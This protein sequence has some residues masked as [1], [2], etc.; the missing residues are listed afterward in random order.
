MAGAGIEVT[1]D[2]QFSKILTALE[3]ASMPDLEAVADFMGGELHD[4]SNTAFQKRADPVTGEGWADLKQP[5]KGDKK[6]TL[7]RGGILFASRNWITEGG[8]FICGSNMEYARIHQEGG[9]TKAYEIKARNGKALSFAGRDGKQV[10]RQSVRH[11]D[12]EIPARARHGGVPK[13]FDRRLL[14]DPA[15]V[16]QLGLG[17]A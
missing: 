5:Y 7:R 1:Y 15:V 11:P 16:K 4:I 2:S 6:S 8:K 10:V 12:S 14:E 13:D 17:G 9:K 3:K